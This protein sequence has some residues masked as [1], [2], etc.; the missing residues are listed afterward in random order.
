MDNGSKRKMMFLGI[1]VI[2]GVI[3][4]SSAYFL[5]KDNA[6]EE[7]AEVIVEDIMEYQMELPPDAL[8]GRIDLS[9]SNGEPEK[10]V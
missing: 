8:R 3:G 7:A 2:V 10:H 9:P 4:I 5:G 6:A 1:L